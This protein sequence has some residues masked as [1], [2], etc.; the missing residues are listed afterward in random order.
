MKIYRLPINIIIRRESCVHLF[1][2]WW[3][4]RSMRC[5]VHSDKTI[6]QKIKE[7]KAKGLTN[8]DFYKLLIKKA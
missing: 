2:K 5:L 8:N 7:L 1:G 6:H 4:D 3:W